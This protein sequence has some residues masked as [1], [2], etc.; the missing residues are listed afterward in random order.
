MMSMETLPSSM[1]NWYKKASIFQTQWQYAREIAPRNG[2]SSKQRYHPLGPKD[3]HDPNTMIVNVIKVGKLTPEE[4]RQCMEKGLCFR[5][6]KDL[7]TIYPTFPSKKLQKVC[8]VKEDLPKL[9]EMEDN[10]ED[11]II[12]KISFTPLDF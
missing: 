6:R 1:N 10:D 8:Q 5:Y 2:Q 9:E 3:T 7:S 4:W 11:E 12:R